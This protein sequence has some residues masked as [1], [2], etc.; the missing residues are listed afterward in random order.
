M[1]IVLKKLIWNEQKIPSTGNSGLLG[2][3]EST[4]LTFN[5]YKYALSEKKKEAHRTRLTRTFRKARYEK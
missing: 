4:N 5:L 3:R 1:R 2:I